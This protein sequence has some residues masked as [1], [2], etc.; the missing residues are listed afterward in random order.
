[1]KKKKEA[2]QLAAT[3]IIKESETY[4]ILS[5]SKRKTSVKSKNG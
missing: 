2:T 4:K 1:M 5:E 3:S